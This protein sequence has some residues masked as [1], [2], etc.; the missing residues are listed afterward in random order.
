MADI[1]LEPTLDGGQFVFKDNGDFKTSDGLYNAGFVAAF[2]A[3]YWGN[4]I[5]DPTHRLVSR[6]NE[7]FNQT[8]SNTTRNLAEQYTTEALAFLE[9]EDIAREIQVDAIIKTST[10]MMITVIITKPDGTEIQ[11][12]YGLNWEAQAVELPFGGII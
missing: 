6:L 3:P 11:L 8:V 10:Y 5:S 2:S 7:L 4:Q 1:V 9:T 12:A